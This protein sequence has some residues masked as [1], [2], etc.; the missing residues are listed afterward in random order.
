MGVGDERTAPFGVG[1]I[2]L[3]NRRAMTL[4]VL[5][6]AVG[7]AISLVAFAL[8]TPA[9]AQTLPTGRVVGR[10]IDAATGQGIPDAG[11]AAA[12]IAAQ[13]MTA[14]AECG[15]VNEALDQLGLRAYN[16]MAAAS[17]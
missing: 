9:E 1:T 5:R 7:V 16:L 15:T 17:T 12:Q 10:V 2:H 4:P 3:S 6:R 13:V 8:Q 14:S 11:T